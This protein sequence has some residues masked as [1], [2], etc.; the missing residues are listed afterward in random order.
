VPKQHQTDTSP[1]T[2]PTLSLHLTTGRA[3]SF[4][5]E[6]LTLNG[7]IS[8]M[9]NSPSSSPPL[10]LTKAPAC[11]AEP[12]ECDQTN[13]ERFPACLGNQRNLHRGTAFQNQMGQ[14]C[15]VHQW[16][17]ELKGILWGTKYIITIE[18]YPQMFQRLFC[19]S[20]LK[21]LSSIRVL[22]P[23]IGKDRGSSAMIRSKEKSSKVIS[24][25]ILTSHIAYQL[26]HF[27]ISNCQDHV[28][29]SRKRK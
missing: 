2:W 27:C 26:H 25:S 6:S 17:R 21:F 12:K 13:T 5:K 7:K 24:V 8:D 23:T 11:P 29:V 18:Q 4:A 1:C 28:P 10:L 19:Y 15:V 22:V 20:K 3:W 9:S 14:E 16:K